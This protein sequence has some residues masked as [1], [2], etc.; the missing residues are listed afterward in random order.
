MRNP[1]P[2]PEKV[3]GFILEKAEEQAEQIRRLEQEKKELELTLAASREACRALA[4]T[5][6]EMQ[7]AMNLMVKL[8]NEIH[9]DV[10]SVHPSAKDIKIAKK[11]AESKEVGNIT[12][13]KT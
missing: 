4:N 11:C 12:K 8:A 2:L 13:G 5:L 10:T 1:T 9:L 6:S 3:D 7:Q